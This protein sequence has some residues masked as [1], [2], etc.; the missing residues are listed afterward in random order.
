MFITSDNPLS[1]PRPLVKAK[2]D[3]G[4]YAANPLRRVPQLSF[5][6]GRDRQFADRDTA[7]VQRRRIPKNHRFDRSSKEAGRPRTAVSSKKPGE[8][9]AAML[10]QHG[11]RCRAAVGFATLSLPS[12]D[13]A[14]WALRAWLDS[15]PGIAT[16]PACTVRASTCNSPS[17]TTE[18]GARP[19]ARPGWSTR[20]RAR[21]ALDRSARRGMRSR[22]R[23]GMRSRRATTL[24]PS[25]PW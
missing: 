3:S 22:G 17:T 18:A 9:L 23:R 1:T 11:Q 7:S 10:D 2:P 20:R 25:S 8:I 13:R 4:I 24:T 16:S 12:Y 5:A 14:L 19:S 15:W 21:P 6:D